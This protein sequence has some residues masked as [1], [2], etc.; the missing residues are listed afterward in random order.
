MITTFEL[1]NSIFYRMRCASVANECAGIVVQIRTRSWNEQH[2]TVSLIVRMTNVLA[3]FC[4]IHTTNASNLL[5][6]SLDPKMK[7]ADSV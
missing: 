6:L 3:P 1:T 5:W 2:G 7:H 4:M